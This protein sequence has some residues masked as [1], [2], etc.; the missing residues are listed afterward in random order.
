VNDDR[1]SRYLA[2]QAE[3]ITLTPA[4]PDGVMRRGARRRTHRRTALVG[5][6]AI[7]AVLGTTV[8]LRDGSDDQKVSVDYS[9]PDVVPS[10]FEW[11]TVTPGTGLA[12]S[13]S[14]V[15]LGG[16]VY[17]LST[18]PAAET[19][20]ERGDVGPPSLYRSDDGAE[21]ARVSTPDGVRVS[22][23]A[24]AGDTLYALGTAPA[25]GGTRDL[26]LS[27]ST[28]GASTWSNLTLPRDVAELEA[29]HPGKVFVST[30][31]IVA[32]D[33]THLVAN[34]GVSANLDPSQYYPEMTEADR[35]YN[36]EWT[37]EGLVV[38]DMGEI[39]CEAVTPRGDAPPTDMECMAQAR[40]AISDKDQGEVVFQET[41][42]ELGIDQELRGLIGGQSI[43]YVSDDGA[44]FERVDVPLGAGE[45]TSDVL[46][47]ADGYWMARGSTDDGG[48][49]ILRSADGRT[50]AV[51]TTLPGSPGEL[52]LLGDRVAVSLYDDS[53]NHVRVQ[54][55]GGP[56]ADLNL[57]S[58]V[59]P[60]E[61]YE[62]W[63]S[64]V[65]FGP[66]GLAT[67]I[68][69]SDEDGTSGESYI[70]HTTDGGTISVVPLSDLDEDL[71]GASVVGTTVTADA[72]A[73]RFS[74]PQDQDPGTPPTQVVLVGTP[75][76]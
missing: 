50:W 17:S 62:A 60:A 2:D 19:D 9:N 31:R 63:M 49:T 74:L 20:P 8:A 45:W 15:Q 54:Q 16:A 65:A 52:G 1:I 71:D 39:P 75:T 36:S 69:T 26:V 5:S 11:S 34:I 28:D 38:R 61:G 51:D 13:S 76:G 6:L 46:A 68:G 58:A 21:W 12:W 25:G 24:T 4:D 73:V 29:R 70:V 18:A 53:G 43:T 42:D 7:V 3:G 10:G 33:A 66:L 57:T 48:A 44:T 23:L 37:A 30:P 40:R 27:T 47:T 64:E 35:A 56:W 55:P 72:V 22:S 67:V 41:Y 59:A 32:R 14:S